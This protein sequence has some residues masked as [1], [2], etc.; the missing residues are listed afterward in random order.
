V[1]NEEVIMS[2][3][4][5]TRRELLVGAGAAA[6]A[7]IAATA[8]P[9]GRAAAASSA[10]GPQESDAA[11]ATAWFDLVSTLV[12]TTPGFS[13]PVAS[14]AFGYAGITLYE[15]V[16]PGS[17]D[18]RSL[19]RVLPGFD[20]VPGGSRQLHWEAVANAALAEIV[21]SLFPTA[22][23]T[24]RQAIDEL[25][26]AFDEQFGRAAS[27]QL[28]RRSTDHGR[29]VAAAV[30]EQSRDDGGHEGYARN[31]PRDYIAPVGPGLWVPTPIEFQRALQ[32]T[33]GGNRCLAIA[34]GTLCPPGDHTA[35]SLDPDSA[36]FAEAAEVYETVND[37]SAEEEAIARFWSDDPGTTATPPGH[38]VSIATQ[39][40]RRQDAPLMTAAE[41]YAKV[42]LAVCDAFVACWNA[43]FR[44]NLLR[45]VT[46]IRRQIE[47]RWLP[48]LSTPPFPEYP[49]GHSVQSGASFAVLA[50]LFG[51]DYAFEDRTH[52]QLDL[53]P[54]SFTSFA[55]AAEEAAIS[56]L[57][58]GI[59]YRAAIE[60]GLAQ[61]RCIAEIVNALPLRR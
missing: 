46:Y 26:S 14:R 49:S 42:G 52:D 9:V 23:D 32:P 48:L 60:L 5:W 28:M 20:S 54:R 8:L 29:R 43:K 6:V 24:G 11:V 59:H 53:P 17:P 39:V 50:D 44:Y 38:T 34:D 1:T 35:F 41:T 37:L 27:P 47:P 7:T 57:Y 40:L 15:S 56:R 22:D 21:R 19:D 58:G 10:T 12:R 3:T 25:E 4:D 31:F 18:Y 45:P 33:W 51:E 30:F 36:F 2:P 55:A 13:P 61:G 16:V